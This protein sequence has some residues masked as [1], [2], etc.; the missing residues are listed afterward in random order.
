MIEDKTNSYINERHS[1]TLDIETGQKK[2][3]IWEMLHLS[4]ATIPGMDR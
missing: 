1:T 2:V 4:W 3:E